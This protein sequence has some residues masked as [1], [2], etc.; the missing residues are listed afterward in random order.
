L[1]GLYSHQAGIG[2]MMDDRGLDGYR[3]DLNRRCVTIA[4]ALRPAGYGTYA[5]GKWHVTKATQPD[6]RKDNWPLQRGF[7]RY[8]G[9]ITGAG[10]FYDPGTLTRDNTMISPYADPEYQPKRYYYTDAISEHAVRFIND[11]RQ[12]SPDKPFFLYV[13]FTC[14]H[15]PM[16]ALEEDIAKY[17]GKYDAGYEAIRKA[18]LAKSKQL[19]LLRKDEELSPTA[20][21]WDA[22]KNKEWETRCMEVYAAMIDRMDQGI[23]RIVG[24]LEKAGQ[25]DNTLIFFL[26][27]N[28]G[29]A[30]TVGRQPNADVPAQ[31]P[32][33]PP[34]EPRGNDFIDTSVR[35]TRTRDGYN[36]RTGPGAMPGPYDTFIAYGQGWANVSNTPFREYKHWVHEGGISTPLIVH[37]PAG[38]KR[39]GE[40]ERTPGHLIDI[41]ATCVDVAGATYP[42]EHAGQAIQPMEGKS[43]A[44]LFAG[45][46]IEREA[47]YWEHEGNRA[48]RV[49]NWKLVAKGPAGKW[50]LYDIDRDRSELHDLAADEPERVKQMTQLWEAWARRAN[51]LPWIWQPQYGEQAAPGAGKK[52][53]KQKGGKKGKKAKAKQGAE[54]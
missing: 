8:Y 22:V 21:D 19:G 35:P 16:H 3:G 18:R 23:A 29:C 38:N 17:R 31:R 20:G 34:L 9:T 5:V 46:P 4:E 48:V 40:L 41:M 47:I 26:Q 15:W 44:P 33:K 11:H 14:A 37:W 24:A 13:A 39:R 49:G 53:G 43:L 51:V 52:A 36:V 28:G 32:E 45:K 25:L 7:D 30:E 1:T 50:E 42:K 10:S 2:H 6:G 12:K 54:K 27:D